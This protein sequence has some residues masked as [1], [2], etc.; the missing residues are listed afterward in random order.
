MEVD[1]SWY[2]AN[3]GAPCLD[4]E[5]VFVSLDNWCQ[6]RE[7]GVYTGYKVGEVPL[8]DRTYNGAK[9]KPNANGQ[10]RC[11]TD[12]EWHD[13]AVFAQAVDRPRRADGLPSCCGELPAGIVIGGKAL[14]GGIRGGVLF[15]GRFDQTTAS[16]DCT[17]T[18]AWNPYVKGPAILVNCEPL[19][20]ALS[21]ALFQS[22]H[23]G[24][25]YRVTINGLLTT[26]TVKV[27]AGGG[28]LTAPVSEVDLGPGSSSYTTTITAPVA[29]PFIFVR[30]AWDG[31]SLQPTWYTVISDL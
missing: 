4:V 12:E 28:C 9:P 27:L 25:T 26:S 19:G 6:E 3:K 22:L 7:L 1:I 16:T 8:R 10:H 15:S 30:V 21:W 24:Q 5:S 18:T 13:G 14:T 17:A 23:P 2:P 31:L 20:F 11:G 29:T